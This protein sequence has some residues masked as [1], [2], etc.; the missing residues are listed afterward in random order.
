MDTLKEFAALRDA[1]LTSEQSRAIVY[2]VQRTTEAAASPGSFGRIRKDPQQHPL[3][4]SARWMPWVAYCLA[5]ALIVAVS[6]LLGR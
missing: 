2:F 1:G 6:A 5:L 3:P 4:A